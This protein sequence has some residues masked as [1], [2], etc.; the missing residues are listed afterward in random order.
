[1]HSKNRAILHFPNFVMTFLPPCKLNNSGSLYL[2]STL[3]KSLT[4]YSKDSIIYWTEKWTISKFSFWLCYHLFPDLEKSPGLMFSISNMQKKKKK[5][6]KTGQIFCRL[7][8]KE[9]KL[10]VFLLKHAIHIM[11]FVVIIIL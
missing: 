8:D 11:L 10:L 5:A 3:S 7:W 2:I 1:M 4:E 6:L 9:T